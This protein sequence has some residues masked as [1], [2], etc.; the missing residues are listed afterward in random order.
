MR[1][2]VPIRVRP[3]SS[4]ASSIS[5]RVCECSATACPSRNVRSTMGAV[6]A[7]EVAVEHEER[8][9]RALAGQHVEQRRRRGRVRTV[10]VGKI[11]GGRAAA[12]M[13]QREGAGVSASSRNGKGAICESNSTPAPRRRTAGTS[14]SSWS[15]SAHPARRGRRR[16]RPGPGP[17][18]LPGSRRHRGSTPRQAS[19]TRRPSPR[20]IGRANA[21]AWSSDSSSPATSPIPA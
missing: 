21:C 10:V 20:P 13:L 9:D 1:S 16:D 6:S 15:R 7:G 12:G 2:A 11:D 4:G 14:V 5:R 18:R 8:R 19:R 3:R 17:P